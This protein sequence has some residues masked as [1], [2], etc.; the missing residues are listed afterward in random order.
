M[1][2]VRESSPDPLSPSGILKIPRATRRALGIFKIS[3]VLRGIWAKIPSKKS[4][5]PIQIPE[6]QG[7]ISKNS[8]GWRNFFGGNSRKNPE[9]LSSFV[10]N[11]Q[12]RWLHLQK[13]SVRKVFSTT[14]E[15]KLKKRMF[16][17]SHG[18]LQP[19]DLDRSPVTGWSVLWMIVGISYQR[20]PWEYILTKA[21]LQ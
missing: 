17:K 14:L 15:K 3:S 10:F 8:R 20:F 18:D 2:F 13:S 4:Q 19:G 12:G 5:F 9:F 7:N 21:K 16:S 1:F 11:H 6:T